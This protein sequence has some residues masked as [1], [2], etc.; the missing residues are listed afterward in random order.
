ML[1]SIR[2]QRLLPSHPYRYAVS[3]ASSWS[4]HNNAKKW[5]MRRAL[6]KTK[7]IVRGLQT[8]QMLKNKT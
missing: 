3:E 7:V 5:R 2:K 1:F 4:M 8:H 6:Y